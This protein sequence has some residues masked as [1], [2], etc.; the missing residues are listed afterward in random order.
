MAGP[1]Q[2]HRRHRPRRPGPDR[3]SRRYFPAQ[4]GPGPGWKSS[5]P[6]ARHGLRRSSLSPGRPVVSFGAPGPRQGLPR[7]FPL[8]G[9]RGAPCGPAGPRRA[10]HPGPPHD[11]PCP[12][13]GS[14]CPLQA[15]ATNLGQGG[16]V[17]GRRRRSSSSRGASSRARVT[18]LCQG[19]DLGAQ[20]RG[21]QGRGCRGRQAGRPRTPPPGPLRAYRSSPRRCASS[22]PRSR[23]LSS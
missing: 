23:T 7:A 9:P 8:P 1:D 20:E 11:G 19:V 12:G 17:S 3:A 4:D 18:R 5:P 10:R 21:G 16:G 2:R 22:P 13:L 14:S 6:P 15:V